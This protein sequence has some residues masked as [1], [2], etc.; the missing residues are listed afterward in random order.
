M[1]ISGRKLLWTRMVT[2]RLTNGAHKNQMKRALMEVKS[3]PKIRTKLIRKVNYRLAV[4]STVK[5]LMVDAHLIK[6]TCPR[7]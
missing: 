3:I 6:M 7:T 4:T 2:S 5:K 1:V